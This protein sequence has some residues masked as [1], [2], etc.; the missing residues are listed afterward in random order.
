MI[1]AASRRG[2]RSARNHVRD[3]LAAR[4]VG[5]RLAAASAHGI[6]SF[7]YGLL[8]GRILAFLGSMRRDGSD[9]RYRYAST[10][11]EPTLYASAYA[12]MT[13]SLLGELQCMPEVARR[14]WAAYFDSF[15]REEDGLFHDAAVMNAAYPDS[16]WWGARHLALH[17]ISAYTDLG[18]RPR[19][20]FRFLHD[21][22]CTDRL[23]SWLDAQDWTS[24]AIGAGDVDNKIM[25]IGC[26]MQ[27]QRDQ[28]G[29]AAAATAVDFLKRYLRGKLDAGSGMWGGF[30]ANDPHE[31]SRMVQFAYHLLPLFFYDGEF[32]FDFDAQ[33]LA[34][35]VLDTQ[36]RWGGYGV[37]ANSSAC[38]DIDSIDLLVRLHPLLPP[39]MQMEVDASLDRALKWVLV[40]QAADGGFVFRLDEPFAFGSDQ[41]S[42]GRNEG[43][44]LP[45]WFRTLSLAYLTRHLGVRQDF[46]VTNC[47]GYEIA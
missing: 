44:M 35:H 19:H 1:L 17:M 24:A 15:Q 23:R 12:C 2:M 28:W 21:Y 29:D 16:D 42:S 47:P 25:N 5:R 26:L 34:R 36:N 3:L 7:D 30:R 27:Y 4:R 43:A 18:L 13:L 45:T 32:E 46:V 37:Q 40:N 31:R 11:T 6:D 10:S 20:P 14:Q 38:E 33:Q 22:C 8:K 41:T 39:A 9:F